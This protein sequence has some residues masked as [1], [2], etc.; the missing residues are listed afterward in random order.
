MKCVFVINNKNNRLRKQWPAIKRQLQKAELGEPRYIFTQGAKHAIEI[1]KQVT[2]EGCDYLIAVGGDGTLHEVVNGV[3]LSGATEV[4][5]PTIG[6]LPLG[7]AND[8]ARTAGITDSVEELVKWLQTDTT[9]RVDLGKIEFPSQKEPRYFINIAGFG[10]GAE[11]VQGLE[12]AH[13]FWGPR[14]N[15]FIHIIKGF[16]KYSKK[17]V[18]CTGDTCQW[19]G[20]MLQLAV[21]NGRYFGNAIGIAPD[22]KLSDGRMQIAIFGDL[23][24]WD[25]LRNLG[26]LKRAVRISHPQVHYHTSTKLLLESQGSCGVEADGEFVGY[27]PA[28][29]SI[30]PAA[31]RFLME[32]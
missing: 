28:A 6:L 20:K 17:E 24:V 2:A 25:Y 15:Y 14:L 11:V 26:K 22:A 21:A 30:V 3:M 10:L 7:S 23:S 19:A 12:K 5:Y 32:G 27:T 29:I 31:I 13:P 8:F 18:R 9:V 1:G 16:L 4:E